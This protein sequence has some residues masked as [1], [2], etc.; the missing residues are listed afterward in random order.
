MHA[1]GH[2]G[3]ASILVFL[4]GSIRTSSPFARFFF[5]EYHWGFNGRQ[6][7]L[8]IDEAVKRLRSDID[9]ARQI[10]QARTQVPSEFLQALEGKSPSAIVSS[11]EAKAFG[12][13]EK[14]GDLSD[15]GDSGDSGMRVVVFT[16]A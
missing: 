2:V 6:T 1:V 16:P 15:S 14:V 5:H 11:E 3:S 12:L 8:R 7:L 13:V 4:A 10:I 9:L